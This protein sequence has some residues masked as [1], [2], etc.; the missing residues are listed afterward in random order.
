MTAEAYMNACQIIGL[1]RSYSTRTPVELIIPHLNYWF[2]NLGGQRKVLIRGKKAV[3]FIRPGTE[4][5][6]TKKLVES[7]CKKF[8]E[9]GYKDIVFDKVH[10]DLQETQISVVVR[11]KKSSSDGETLVGG[12]QIQNSILGLKPLVMS[13]YVNHTV[14][15]TNGGMIS[16]TTTGQWDRRLGTSAQEISEFLERG[17]EFDAEDVYSVYD[18]AGQATADVSMRL[19]KEFGYVTRLKNITVGAHAG[20]FFNDIYKKYNIP[21][22]LRKAVQEEYADRDGNSVYDLWAAF[23]AVT[24]RH[25]VRGNPA[26]MRHMM[27]VA[28]ELAAHPESCSSCHRLL[29]VE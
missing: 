20:V 5:Y 9:H 6:S 3:A 21:I 25:E 12:A 4:I 13:A 10:H 15:D 18:W 1:G 11:D 16:V 23:V 29:E 14:D 27:T 28:G 22:S 7:M 2:A 8:E 17:I 19:D 24:G 26:A